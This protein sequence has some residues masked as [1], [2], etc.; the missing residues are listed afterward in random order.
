MKRTSDEFSKMTFDREP[1]PGVGNAVWRSMFE[2][3]KQYSEQIAYP[4]RNFPNLDEG[5]RCVLCQHVI[6]ADAKDRFERFREFVTQDLAFKASHARE[7]FNAA[8]DKMFVADAKQDYLDENLLEE[9]GESSPVAAAGIVEAVDSL[10]RRAESI[11]M[12]CETG[13]WDMISPAKTVCYRELSRESRSLASKAKEYDALATPEE[14]ARLKEE[15]TSL[16][17]RK[18]L[19][20]NKEDVMGFLGQLKNTHRLKMVF[21]DALTTGIT[22]KQSELMDK[23]VTEEL[24]THLRDE[25][26]ALGLDYL[27]FKYDK[28]GAIGTTL[29]QLRLVNAQKTNIAVGDILSDGETRAVAVAG[30]L[31]E[32]QTTSSNNGI[33][34][35]DPVCSL[36]HTWREKIAERLIQESRHR[37]VIVFTHD[38]VLLLSLEHYAGRCNVP[39]IRQS[40]R[41]QGPQ[42]GIID[43]EHPWE[44]LP[45]KKRIEILRVM[46]TRASE[47]FA[48]NDPNYK[49]LLQ[50]G[51]GY[52]REAWERTIEILLFADT[53]QRYRNAIHTQN[54]RYVE[55][56]DEDYKRIYIGV[57]NASR[58]LAGHDEA[59]ATGAPYPKPDQFLQD[60]ENLAT[61]VK[62]LQNR[63]NDTEERRKSLIAPSSD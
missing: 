63:R 35:D 53:V 8:I 4:G 43:P 16:S 28:R 44:T 26:K 41:R 22:R 11:R 5:S 45:P 62:E 15:L 46:R 60:I 29:H 21:D 18:I 10:K 17:Q 47:C 58:W 54:L 32:L 1:L 48:A 37:Q 50:L 57:E 7:L 6:G 34:F 59:A 52:L 49:K 31:A 3:A 27:A 51:Y 56:R 2:A 25:L 19:C 12:A 13:V 23:A 24:R 14:K 36:D 38:I 20:E 55:V 61:F 33:V 30:F 9:I 39:F 40:I 42:C